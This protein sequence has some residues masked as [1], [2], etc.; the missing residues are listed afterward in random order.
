[1]CNTITCNP[2][3]ADINLGFTHVNTFLSLVAPKDHSVCAIEKP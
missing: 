1:M 2:K 3:C